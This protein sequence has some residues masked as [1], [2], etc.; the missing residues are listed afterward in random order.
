MNPGASYGLKNG[1]ST[2]ELYLAFASAAFVGRRS[3]MATEGRSFMR[4]R[5]KDRKWLTK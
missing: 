5:I 3:T 4:R 2:E 1:A